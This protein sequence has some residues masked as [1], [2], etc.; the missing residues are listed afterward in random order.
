LNS[1]SI[2]AFEN[3]KSPISEAY[4]MLRT[5]I[6]FANV[7][8]VVKTIL[9]TSAGPAEG[10]TS[11]VTN[12][13]ITMAQAGKKV[14]IIDADM[15]K[16]SIHKA[17][18]LQNRFGL[19]NTLVELANCECY[20][21]HTLQEGLDVITM[22]PIPPNPSELLGSQRMKTILGELTR[23]YDYILID[24]PPVLPVTD[25]AILAQIVD[26]VILVIAANSTS[27]EH[28]IRAKEKLSGVG[29]KIIGVVLNKIKTK[30]K[31]KYYYYY[32]YE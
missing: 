21:V 24:S 32:H 10:K 16:P 7:D 9:F 15:R 14:L 12:V 8:R 13:G 31:D 26:G 4:R 6:Q 3:P 1:Y 11:T 25:A 29:A 23:H 27:H 18:K 28:A 20:I 19:S 17:L 5:N 2:K 30:S 22:G